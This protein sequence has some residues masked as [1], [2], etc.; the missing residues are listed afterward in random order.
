MQYANKAELMDG[1]IKK[2]H[3]EALLEA[4]TVGESGGM[5]EPQQTEA[6]SHESLKSNQVKT[7]QP[8]PLSRQKEKDD[9][10]GGVMPLQEQAVIS[11]DQISLRQ[12]VNSD[13]QI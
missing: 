7:R 13:G 3:P 6:Q 9:K 10:K 12:E 11:N 2:Y 1:I 5:A 8:R 4:D